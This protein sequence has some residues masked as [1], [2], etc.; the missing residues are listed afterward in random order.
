M[1]SFNSVQAQADNR[2]NVRKALKA[3]VFLAPISADP[4]TTIVGA[5]KELAEIPAEYLPVGLINESISMSRE[6]DREETTALGYKTPVR[7]DWTTD[8]ST[9]TLNLFEVDKRNVAELVHGVDLSEV[10]PNENGEIAYDVPEITSSRQYKLLI[11]SQDINKSNLLDIY[12][13][14]FYYNVELSSFPSEELGSDAIS[15]EIELT[16]RPD[17]E[18]GA[19]FKPFLGGPGFDPTDLG[20]AASAG[21]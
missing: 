10:A 6:A 9:I 18:T 4:I 16:A 8:V 1:V 20:Y 21:E 12:R 14:R 15:L 2:S 13:A 5:D 7:E 3:L 19:I 17:E 11:L